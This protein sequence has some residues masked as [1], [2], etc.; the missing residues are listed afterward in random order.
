VEILNDLGVLITGLAQR[1]I[2][3][4]GATRRLA[5]TPNRA[6][7]AGSARALSAA[8]IM[9]DRQEGFRRAEAP[10]LA[11]GAAVAQGAVA[12]DGANEVFSACPW[13]VNTWK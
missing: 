4:A 12:A 9:A 13:L 10:A 1:R 8:T 2:L 5:G 6:A 3:S 7:R 11:E